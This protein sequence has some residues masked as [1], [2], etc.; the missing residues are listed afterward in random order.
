MCLDRELL[1]EKV[2]KAGAV[3]A[4][5]FVPPGTA[6]YHNAAQLDFKD[7]PMDRRRAEARRLLAEAGYTAQ[8]PLEFEFRTMALPNTR[9]VIITAAALLQE[10][11]IV[12][13]IFLSESKVYYTALQMFDFTLGVAAWGADYNDPLTFLSLLDS[14][15]GPYNYQ[16]YANQ[17]YDRMMDEAQNTQDL[18]LRAGILAKAE[19]LALDESGVIPLAVSSYRELVAPHVKGYAENATS[20]HRTRWMRIE[21]P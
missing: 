1:T 8:H 2:I 20:T 3:P 21:R 11:G 5:S 13:H 9:R 17:A 12:P 10:C 18:D 7:W 4:Y 15:A 6:G 19:Q 16:G 14:R